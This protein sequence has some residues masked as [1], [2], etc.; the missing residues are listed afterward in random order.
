MLTVHHDSWG[1]GPELEQHDKGLVFSHGGKNAGFTNDL[2]AY[3]DSANGIVI[4]SNGDNAGP[5]I[6]ELKI[7][8]SVH[9][10][11]DLASSLL[12]KPAELAEK[13]RS[14]IVGTY[15]FDRDPEYTV[16]IALH[17]GKIEVHDHGRDQKLQFIATGEDTITNLTSGSK[18]KF[19]TDSKGKL[20][21]L[22]WAGSYK[23][24]KAED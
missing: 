6:E 19:N 4:M 17:K 10:G 8:I 3:A 14:S 16:S 11:W 5:L 9:Y 24:T 21:G 2:L 22:T 13:F 18:V 15:S 23:F 12:L 20:V 7:A 1:L